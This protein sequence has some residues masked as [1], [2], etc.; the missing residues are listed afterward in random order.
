MSKV[1]MLERPEGSSNFFKVDKP[2]NYFRIKIPLQLDE[3]IVFYIT[4][5]VKWFLLANGGYN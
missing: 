2:E 4:S 1:W 3:T 5:Q